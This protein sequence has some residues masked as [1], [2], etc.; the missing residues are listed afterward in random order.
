MTTKVQERRQKLR[1]ALIDAAERNIA[2]HGL[3]KLTARTLAQEA[4]CALGAIYNVFPDLDALVVAV[5]SRTLSELDRAIA[6][7]VPQPDAGLKAQDIM[8]GLALTYAQFANQHRN[9]WLALFD[10]ALQSSQPVPDWHLDEHL[11]LIGRVV[12]GLKLIAP[13]APDERLQLVARALFSAVHGIVQLAIQGRF[14]SVPPGELEEQ[15]KLVVRSVTRGLKPE[16]T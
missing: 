1:V 15:I 7:T 3:A 16:L 6:Q 11:R 14:L 2:A 5:N 4:G 13:N 12:D 8:V 10:F 9:L